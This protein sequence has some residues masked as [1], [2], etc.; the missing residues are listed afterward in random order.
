MKLS[1]SSST[2]TL[3]SITCKKRLVWTCRDCSGASDWWIVDDPFTVASQQNHQ[4]SFK[5]QLSGGGQHD[6]T[7]QSSWS[8]NNNGVATVGSGTGLVHGVSPGGPIITAEDD[9]V[10][11]AGENCGAPPDPCPFDM[12]MY[13]T[14]PGNVVFVTISIRSSGTAASDNAARGAYNSENGTYNLGN[15]V[16]GG[17][18]P[19]YCSIG[20]EAD[21]TV[22]PSN[23][24]GTINLVRTNGGSN[25]SGSNGQTLYS[26]YP[27]GTDDTSNPVY[28]D[29]NPQSGGSNG[30][31]SI[32]MPLASSLIRM[33]SGAKGLTSS[34]TPSY[35]TGPMWR[36][37]SA[38]MPECLVVGDRVAIASRLTCLAIMSLTWD[39]LLQL[40]TCNREVA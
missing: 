26:S 23:Y 17:Q 18:A 25:Y 10:A 31:V 6:V 11:I 29:T 16:S 9:F 21:G 7:T 22:S 1:T 13:E 37:R 14:S 35:P 3:A 24:A 30:K 8:N 2:S 20:F 4:L 28:L 12:G 32:W 19:G 40:G 5:Y 27:P 39:R 38:F 15:F 33:K 34:K 36:M